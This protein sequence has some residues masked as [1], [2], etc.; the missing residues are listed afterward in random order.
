MD[1]TSKPED[2]AQRLGSTLARLWRAIQSLE[3]R[4]G[5]WLAYVGCSAWTSTLIRWALRAAFLAIAVYG[6]VAFL[7][8]LVAILLMAAAFSAHDTPDL[9]S[10]FETPQW[11]DGIEGYGCYK[12][13]TRV[14]DH[15]LF[16]SDTEI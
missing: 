7:L 10:A 12:G 8:A 1:L 16:E 4:F 15:R 13:G 11:R 5:V 9:A 6:F 14:D 2:R 3:D